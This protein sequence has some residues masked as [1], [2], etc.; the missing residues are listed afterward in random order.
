MNASQDVLKI[1]SYKLGINETIISLLFDRGLNTEEKI[2]TFLYGSLD[3]LEPVSIFTDG[4]KLK[5]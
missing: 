5:I 3:D 2:K 1:I 4:V